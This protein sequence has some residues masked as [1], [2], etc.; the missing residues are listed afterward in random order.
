[1]KKKILLTHMESG[2]KY[3]VRGVSG[4]MRQCPAGTG[5]YNATA[6]G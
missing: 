4:F 2:K 6:V 1:M 3:E 5:G